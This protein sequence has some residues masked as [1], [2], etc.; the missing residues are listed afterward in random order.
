MQIKIL[1]ERL[2][3]NGGR[4]AK[5]DIVQVDS[6]FKAEAEG[7]GVGGLFEVVAEP[8]KVSVRTGRK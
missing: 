2:R 8:V 1:N 7:K 5:G 4:W 6:G 3:A